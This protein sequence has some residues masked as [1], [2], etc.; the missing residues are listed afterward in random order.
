MEF[1]APPPL[2][3]LFQPGG[4][5]DGWNEDLVLT[6]CGMLALLLVDLC[7]VR[8]FLKPSSRFFALHALANAVVVC[9]SFPDVLRA[10]TEA[11]HTT[12]SGRSSTMVANSFV[13]S[14][15]LYHCVA[16]DLTA[17]DVFHHLLFVAVLCGAAVPFKNE[18]GV[19]NK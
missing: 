2:S 16:F 12:F 13:T 7:L 1:L 5:A 4:F 19:A 14:V 15:H 11:G 9:A 8:P 17:A 6:M 3:P 10:L 18:G